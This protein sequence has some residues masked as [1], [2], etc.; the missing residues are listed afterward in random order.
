MFILAIIYGTYV[1]RIVPLFVVASLP[2]MSG[3]TLIRNWLFNSKNKLSLLDYVLLWFI[4][5][6]I[7]FK[8]FL[9]GI[10]LGLITALLA[11]DYRY[12][13]LS[14]VRNMLTGLDLYSNNERGVAAEAFLKD[15]REGIK[16]VILQGYLFFGNINTVVEQL[17]NKLY[18]LNEGSV[19]FF[20]LDFRNVQG[21]DPSS[22]GSFFR[23][24][25]HSKDR[26]VK[27]IFTHISSDTYKKMLNF[28][29]LS[30]DDEIF[31]RFSNLDYG[32]EWCEDYFLKLK[33]IN[34]Y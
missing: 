6:I 27:V 16:I 18:S 31:L 4:F 24:Y 21:M 22:A 10:V 8:G 19:H 7:I 1:I 5:I 26:N 34:N 2:L 13:R 20:I 23:L 14:T 25:K 17:I 30:Q 29:S 9:I 28:L 11:F 15:Y 12:S 3:V 32:L 33:S